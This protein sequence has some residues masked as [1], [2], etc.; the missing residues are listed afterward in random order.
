MRA[1]VSANERETARRAQI[2]AATYRAF[3]DKGFHNVTL[4]DISDYAGFS[5]GVTMYYFKSKEE[6]FL[7]LLDWLVCKIG[8]RMQA[9][10]D[11][12][13]SGP[14]KLRAVIDSVFVGARENREFYQVYLDYLSLGSRQSLFRAANAEFYAKCRELNR[15]IVE[16]GVREKAFRPVDPEEG[17]MVI[18]ALVDGLCI[19]WMFDSSANSFEQYKERCLRAVLA[20]LEA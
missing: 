14:A 11:A 13:H 4:Q 6:V 20:Y 18:R 2:I 19:Q 3:I 8:E 15:A 10:V 12:E 1:T 9:N 17:A 5:K 16:Q 7:A